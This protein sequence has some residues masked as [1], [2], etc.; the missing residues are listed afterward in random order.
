MTSAQA[1]DQGQSGGVLA[2]LNFTGQAFYAILPDLELFRVSVAV[3]G[4]SPILPGI[5]WR[6]WIRN[7]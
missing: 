4:D 6:A 5:K 3:V 2:L 1:A 7:R